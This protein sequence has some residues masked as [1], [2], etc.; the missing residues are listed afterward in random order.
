MVENGD[1]LMVA[2][3]FDARGYCVTQRVPQ[4]Q[5]VLVTQALNDLN[6]N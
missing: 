5:L 3:S 4:W 6:S 2:R 1:T